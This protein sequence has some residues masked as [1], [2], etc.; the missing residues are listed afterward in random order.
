MTT[1]IERYYGWETGRIRNV[2]NRY[3]KTELR[4]RCCRWR[5][6]HLQLFAEGYQE[7]TGSLK[8]NINDKMR[9]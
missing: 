3:R 8:N 5:C 4:V 9:W 6:A 1:I 2:E 7:F